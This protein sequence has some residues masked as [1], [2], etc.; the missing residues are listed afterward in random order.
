MNS[1]EKFLMIGNTRWHWAIKFNNEW[2]YFDTSPYQGDVKD[3]DFSQVAWASVGIV[4][5]NIDLCPSKKINL[6]DVPLLNLPSHL[7]IDRALASYSAFQK[8]IYLKNKKEGLLIVDAGTILS[9]TKITEDGGFDGGQLIAGLRLQLSAM[10]KGAFN[11]ENPIIK[12]IPKKNFQYNTTN[13]MI[14]G[15]INSLLGPILQCYKET[16]LTIWLCGGDALVILN[17]LKN[18]NIDVQYQPNLVLEG[19]INIHKNFN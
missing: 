5:N 1:E 4:P 8:Q 19:M 2:K 17:E 6:N 14:R 12:T 13:A 11:L 3:E 7:G 15:T 16:S 9:I 10:A 18:K